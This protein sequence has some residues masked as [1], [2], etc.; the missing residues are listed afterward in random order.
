MINK[1]VNLFYSGIDENTKYNEVRKYVLLNILLLVTSLIIIIFTTF[2]VI[3]KAEY[4]LLWVDILS[5]SANA[6]A[7]YELKVHKA[8]KKASLLATVNAFLLLLAIVYF[9]RAEN[10]TLVWIVFF[11]VF[12]IFINGC[13]KG[14][15]ISSVFY[16]IVFIL[17][18]YNINIWL[19]GL[20][21][22]ASFSRFVAANLGM[23]FITYFFERS[24]EA[25][26]KELAKNRDIQKKYITALE[27]ASITD[28]LTKL[29]NRR[30]LDTLF[31]EQFLKAKTHQSYF[32]F[33]ILDLDYFKGYNDTY[34]HI[35]GDKALKQ[36]S[37]V[38]KESMRRD[39]DAAFR[40]GGE[41]FAG[42]FM[43]DSKEKIC[44]NV[45]NI[46]KK[47][48]ELAIE[49]KK[50][51][52]PVLT[53]SIGVAIIH[54]FSVEDFDKMYKIADKALYEAKKSGRNC[55]KGCDVIST[56]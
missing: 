30:H 29:Y 3:L 51:T 22:F 46:R 44:N 19:N 37:T 26:H 47:V 24:F 25:A 10:F 23:L 49:H 28:P 41:E 42:I 32:A 53:I 45:E 6:Y 8:L 35:A 55:V 12:A 9:A 13:K 33:F 38:L 2:N 15:I 16:V 1:L 54:D 31:H 48:E 11:P 52:Y 39:A 27:K 5:L 14:L 4:N 20:W 17:T 21:D 56:L 43:A 40:L 36:V 34:G 7:F 50:S 18:F